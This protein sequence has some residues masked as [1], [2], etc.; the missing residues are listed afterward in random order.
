MDTVLS[1]V[2]VFKFL[3]TETATGTVM[4]PAIVIILYIIKYRRPHYF[5]AAKALSVDTFHFQG[6]KVECIHASIVIT[7][8]FGT[9]A[10]VQIMPFQ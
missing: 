4:T 9:H 1:K 8:T 7:A 2:L 3:R 6:V 5:P 10:A